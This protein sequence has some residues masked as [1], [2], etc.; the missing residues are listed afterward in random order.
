[1]NLALVRAALAA[2]AASEDTSSPIGES[3]GPPEGRRPAGVLVALFESDGQA[4]VILTRRSEHLNA[5]AGE[6]SFP[7]GGLEMGETV[8]QAA[9]REAYE[10][11]GID[12]RSVEIVADLPALTTLSA[13]SG[14]T[15]VV[16]ILPGRP[17]LVA[18]PNEVALAFDIAL[19]D[20][21]AP[22]VFREELWVLADGVERTIQFYE[23]AHDTIWGA[24]AKIL[25]TF[26]AVIISAVNA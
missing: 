14:I 6:V 1:M 3:V 13:A 4:R 12:P 19:V 17:E 18:N 20:L 5:H 8:R 25:T 11:V 23:L 26:L 2:Y 7:G 22:G 15:P 21:M 24:T 10:E 16:G 9:L